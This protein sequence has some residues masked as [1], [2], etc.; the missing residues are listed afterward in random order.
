VTTR[1]GV[2]MTAKRSATST[3]KRA[4]AKSAPAKSAPGSGPDGRAGVKAWLE[5]IPSEQRRLA[6]RLDAVIL[7]TVPGS[8]SGIKY[9]K[10]SGPLG[11]PFYGL[12]ESGWFLHLNAL[13]GRVRITFFA[14]SAMKP[15]PPLP[16]P[17]G[18]R[19]IDIPSDAEPDEKQITKW[20]QQAA[21]LP[22]WGHI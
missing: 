2:A 15:A 18:S 3:A 20:L 19:A 17:G 16:S 21:K 10:P 5:G 14:G 6:R 22:G 8:V 1:Y 13:K 12:P 9:R 11:V 4:A 7:K